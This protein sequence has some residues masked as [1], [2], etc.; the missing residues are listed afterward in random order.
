MQVV[1]K[2][3][4]KPLTII[5]SIKSTIT[6]HKKLKRYSIG[7]LFAILAAILGA[8][9][10]VLPK[11]ILEGN[12]S[13]SGLNP[14][15]MVAIIYLLNSIMFT[16]LLPKKNPVNEVG[17]RNFL[18]LIIIGVTEIIATTIFYL[19]LK[20]TSAVN[21]AILGNSDIIF[22]SI[23][24][25]IIFRE[26]LQRKEYFSYSTILCGS[27]IIP[28]YIDLA[29]N[30]YQ[31]SQF[32]YG[33][34]LIIFAGLFYGIEMNVYRYLSDKIDA[35]RILQIISF[36]GG[37]VTISLVFLLQIPLEFEFEYMPTILISGMLGIGI[38]VL[39]IVVA[40]KNIG[41]VR[42]ILIFSTTT[43]FGIIFSHIILNEKI[44]SLHLIAFVMVF[45][46]IIL[47]RTKMTD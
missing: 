34:F 35:K 36:V 46:G 27:I 3:F 18:L 44:I 39:F 29:A 45:I 22:T 17:I 8:M 5:K 9:A 10:D 30:N 19:G 13:F 11:P 7:F 33:D 25:T 37:I 15:A 32:V 42:T 6:G 26:A 41:A 21:S 40:I 28:V 23:I 1:W 24:A 14:I 20:N 38:S 47:L 4:W 31:I 2:L 16:G 43:L 12:A